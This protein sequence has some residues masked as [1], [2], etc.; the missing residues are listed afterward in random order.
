MCRVLL[1]DDDGLVEE[2]LFENLALK[3]VGNRQ[4]GNVSEKKANERKNKKKPPKC[5]RVILSL[6]L[7]RCIS[8]ARYGMCEFANK[9]S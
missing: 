8:K 2:V 3:L 7:H 1:H 6:D 4:V 5:I 9:F